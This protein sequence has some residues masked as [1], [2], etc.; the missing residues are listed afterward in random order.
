MKKYFTLFIGLFICTTILAQ[1][2]EENFETVFEQTK[3]DNT[4]TYEQTIEFY[5]KLA[6]IY[7][8]FA[9]NSHAQLDYIYQHS[10]Y[11]EKSFM[12]YPIYRILK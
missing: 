3:G 12:Q 11:A 8:E 1:E 4:A 5:K 2:V 6:K 9:S 10:K 7:P